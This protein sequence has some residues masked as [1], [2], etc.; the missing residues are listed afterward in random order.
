MS[1]S[2]FDYYIKLVTEIKYNLPIYNFKLVHDFNITEAHKEDDL[3][4]LPTIDTE[5]NIVNRF[6]HYNN[7]LTNKNNIKNQ[8]LSDILLVY[9]NYLNIDSTLINIKTNIDSKMNWIV[10]RIKTNENKKN[11]L[12]DDNE[13]FENHIQ[14]EM[15]MKG[16]TNKLKK[17]NDK[18][19]TYFDKEIKKIDNRI[20]VLQSKMKILND[21]LYTNQ[22]I[23]SY[24]NIFIGNDLSEFDVVKKEI[25]D[26]DSMYY[27]DIKV[28]KPVVVNQCCC[29]FKNVSC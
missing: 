2:I 6:E 23:L 16:N 9:N 22:N 25:F 19:K 29:K 14:K 13:Y 27:K 17:V 1:L 4:V 26:D 3:I 7:R 28:V 11:K 5:D 12:I 24:I 21:Y 15:N 20:N 8:K 10:E 18:R